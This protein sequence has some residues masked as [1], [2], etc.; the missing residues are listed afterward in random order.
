VG[1]A[2]S[3]IQNNIQTN[4]QSVEQVGLA[5][6]NATQLSVLSGESLKKIIDF[7]HLV[8]RPSNK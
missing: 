4:I 8:L 3:T 5:I 6:E 2:I 1:N 7:V